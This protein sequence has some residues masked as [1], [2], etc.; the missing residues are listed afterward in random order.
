MHERGIYIPEIFKQMN[1]M[2][3]IK[4]VP[5]IISKIIPRRPDFLLKLE[6]GLNINWNDDI[7]IGKATQ[8]ENPSILTM[9]ALCLSEA[10]I[11][12]ADQISEE[13]HNGPNACIFYIVL[14]EIR[15]CIQMFFSMYN[16]A[17]FE[18]IVKRTFL[19]T[20]G[21]PSNIPIYGL[22]VHHTFDHFI[23]LYN[24]NIIVTLKKE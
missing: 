23:K 18:S 10:R 19:G 2:R 24:G 3:Q 1:Q 5:L 7:C 15:I 4:Y 20:I 6:L 11:L 21:S 13:M 9:C 16:F 22:E 8:Q 17:W 12:Q 14:I